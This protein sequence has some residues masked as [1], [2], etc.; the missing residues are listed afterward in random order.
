MV[1]LVCRFGV[2]AVTDENPLGS[3]AIA[4]NSLP[5]N[6]ELTTSLMGFQKIHE[7]GLDA[8]SA[9]DF[10]LD[11]CHAVTSLETTYDVLLLPARDVT[12]PFTSSRRLCLMNRCVVRA[13]DIP[14]WLKS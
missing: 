10:M 3:G 4:G 9:R 7:H 12:L 2:A 11:T 14:V 13:S 8:T 6:R 1:C 5:I